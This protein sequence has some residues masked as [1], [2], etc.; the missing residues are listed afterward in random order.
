M[1]VPLRNVR[2]CS[3]S[4]KA[5]HEKNIKQP[6]VVIGR[7]TAYASEVYAYIHRHR[8]ENI[9]FLKN[10]VTGELPAIF[11]MSDLFIYPSSFEGFGIPVLEALNSAVPVIA[12]TG[13]CLEETGGPSS[14]YVDPADTGKLG[15]EILRTLEDNSLRRH[16]IEEGLKH[17]LNFTAEKTTQKLHS[18]YESII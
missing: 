6:L 5:I 1:S 8:I 15:D 3:V 16:M 10:I 17:A 18:L 14:V 13:S 4:V 11:R 9:H 2:I 12:G 7:E